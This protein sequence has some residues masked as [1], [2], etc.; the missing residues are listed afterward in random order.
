LAQGNVARPALQRAIERGFRLGLPSGSTAEQAAVGAIWRGDTTAI[1]R[2]SARYS[3]PMQ[4]IGKLYRDKGGWKADWVFV[5]GGRVLSKWSVAEADAR[6]AIAAGA[7]GAA[8]ALTRRYAKASSAGPAGVQRVVITGIRDSDDYIRLSA[9]LQSTSVVRRI[10]PV[11]AMED[12][13]E[14]DLDLL[15][16]LSGFRRVVDGDILAEDDATLEGLPPVFELR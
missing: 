15:T 12:R 2:V 4:L 16:G 7:D 6:R 1:A 5:D 3:P 13:L 8:D 10:S 14:V 9:Y 11:R